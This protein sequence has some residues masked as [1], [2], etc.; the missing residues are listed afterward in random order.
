MRLF[1]GDVYLCQFPLC[2]GAVVMGV[3]AGL[4]SVGSTPAGALGSGGSLLLCGRASRELCEG[5]NA[6]RWS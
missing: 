1:E 6:W 3:M 5:C 2:C 4:V